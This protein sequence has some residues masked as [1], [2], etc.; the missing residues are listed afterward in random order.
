MRQG[1]VL[2]TLILVTMVL[3]ILA[4]V[5]LASGT[6]SLRVAT[7]DQQID[8]AL[9]AAEAG[10][11]RAAQEFNAGGS[12]PQPYIVQLPGSRSSVEVTAYEN[13]TEGDLQVP[14]GPLIPPSTVYLKAEGISENGTRRL[15][16][17]LFTIGLQAFK[18]GALGDQLSVSNASFDAYNSGTG[19][20]NASTIVNDIPLLAS[21]TSSGPT[22]V[23]DNA[24]VAGDIFVGPGGDPDT[25]I[26]STNSTLGDRSAM[27][28]AIELEEITVPDIAEDETDPLDIVALGGL[29]LLQVDANGIYHFDDGNGLEFTIDPSASTPE[30]RINHPGLIEGIGPT[31][32]LEYSISLGVNH[33]VQFN[34]DG[35]FGTYCSPSTGIVPQPASVGATISELIYGGVA[36]PAPTP[37]DVVN[38]D[39][40]EPGAYDSVTLE[41]GWTAQLADGVFV[42]KSLNITG[43]SHLALDALS[44][45]VTLYVTES[46]T[47][48]GEDALLNASKKAPKLKVFYTGAQPV[49]LSGGSQ[50]FFTLVAPDADITLDAANPGIRTQFFGALVGKN[51]TVNNTSFHFDT[52][53]SGIGTGT[54]GSAVSL[55]HRHRL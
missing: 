2:P 23:F 13:T 26:A 4:T 48:D 17:A 35:M 32:Q 38:P 8:Q 25:Q 29:Q 11:V 33:W 47:V 20:Y 19:D 52:A 22:F 43:G 45:G 1:F 54:L 34:E 24:S 12:I 36:P 30:G 5:L 21:N 3:L 27:A 53:T 9:F 31:G 14:G 41:E 46:L 18:V 55:I 42:I 10:L 7:R 44:D 15:A 50:S 37:G 51:V 6:T 39:V 49:E 40:L 28:E 16:G